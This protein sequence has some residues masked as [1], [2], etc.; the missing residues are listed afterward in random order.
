MSDPLSRKERPQRR[1]SLT[2]V[3]RGGL[4]E[5][6]LAQ[7]RGHIA[8]GTW[9]LHHRL[10]PEDALARDLG[11][12]RSTIREA[13]RVLVHTGLL[14]VRQGDG[15]YVRSQREIDAA[16]ARRL[17]DADL[18]EAYEL[19]RALEVEAA[20]LAAWRRTDADVVRLHELL[21]QRAAAYTTGSEA[22][23]RAD[24]ALHERIVA[25]TGNTLL[26]DLYGAFL[27]QSRGGAAS[28]LDDVALTVEGPDSPEMHDLVRAIEAADPE[29]AA[30][31]AERRMDNV[32]RVLRFWLQVVVIHR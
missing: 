23:R 15:T 27:Q 28:D 18:L 24:S 10:P 11:V 19:R 1:G 20:R 14:E 25:V 21:E 3:A 7:L 22:Y 17:M 8:D 4:S 30:A 16:L 32:M 2:P 6:V 31:A 26:A 5:Q 13:V 29:A 9:P 12:G